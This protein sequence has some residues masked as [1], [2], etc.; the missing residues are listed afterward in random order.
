MAATITINL[1]SMRNFGLNFLLP[2]ALV[3]AI[4]LFVASFFSGGFITS[5]DV[6]SFEMTEAQTVIHTTSTPGWLESMWEGSKEETF[7]LRHT[8]GELLDPNGNDCYPLLPLF[9]DVAD[10]FYAL[11]TVKVIGAVESKEAGM[12]KITVLISFNEQHYEQQFIRLRIKGNSWFDAK[13]WHELGYRTSALRDK[14]NQAYGVWLSE[15]AFSEEA[16]IAE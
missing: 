7:R 1:K 8:D 12:E 9:D 11:T 16:E 2:G 3:G 4:L 10:E 15:Q 14:I 5:Y 6:K 13:T